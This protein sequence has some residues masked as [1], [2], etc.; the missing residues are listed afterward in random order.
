MDYNQ[1][2]L[3]KVI[4]DKIELAYFVVD[5]LQVKVIE[6]V[7]PNDPNKSRWF[8]VNSFESRDEN[9]PTAMLHGIDITDFFSPSRIMKTGELIKQELTAMLGDRK[10][11]DLK[12]SEHFYWFL[13]K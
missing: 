5:N 13:Y 6:I 10:M 2:N 7:Y 11:R 4:Q 12:F 9:N 8:I 1:E 3:K